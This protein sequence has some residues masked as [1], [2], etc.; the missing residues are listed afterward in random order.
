M[1]FSSS[2][3]KCKHEIVYS[4]HYLY[5]CEDVV[6][7]RPFVGNFAYNIRTS[8]VFVWHERFECVSIFR[9][10]GGHEMNC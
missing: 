6:S 7:V 9:E 4:S 5:V 8:M 2:Q 3:S 1:P 10:K